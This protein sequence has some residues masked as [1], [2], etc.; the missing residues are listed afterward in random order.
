MQSA[1]TVQTHQTLTIAIS[2][3]YEQA[4]CVGLVAGLANQ[5]LCHPDYLVLRVAL[6]STPRKSLLL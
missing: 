4:E 6:S 2:L 1:Q 5:S 3:D